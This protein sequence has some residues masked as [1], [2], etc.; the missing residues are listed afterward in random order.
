MGG[1]GGGSWGLGKTFDVVFDP[2]SAV[3]PKK[4]QAWDIGGSIGKQ[5][6]INTMNWAEGKEAFGAHSNW[7]GSTKVGD[8]LNPMM[9]GLTQEQVKQQDTNIKA[10]NDYFTNKSKPAVTPAGSDEDKGTVGT[11]LL[12]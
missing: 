4:Y 11:S 1:K 10:W 2:F 5:S 7:F 3:V 6:V 12:G 8:A 9:G